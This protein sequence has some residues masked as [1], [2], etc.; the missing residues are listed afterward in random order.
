MRSSSTARRLLAAASGLGLFA[1]GMF[2]AWLGPAAAGPQAASAGRGSSALPG[3]SSVV[4]LSHVNDPARTPLFP[5]D[6][7]FTIHTAFTIAEDGFFLEVLHEGMHTGTHYSAPCHF[8]A[9]AAC[10]PDLAPSDLVLPAAVIDVRAQVRTDPDHV[11]TIADLQAWEAE[12]GDLPAGGAV[13]LFT[14]C[15]RFW[16]D[17]DTD[18]EPNYYNCGSGRSGFHQPGF[19]RNAVKWLIR[20]GVLGRTGALGS[21]TF[22]PDPSADASFTPTSLT[23]HKHRVTIENLTHLGELPALGAWVVLGSPRNVH[24]SGAPGSVFAFLP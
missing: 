24:G 17:G 15:S 3:F 8:H 2:A 18:G 14:G 16:A 21:D 9:G 13:L 5:G 12:H 6:P 10:M 22:G 23:L 20:T 11:V 4:I 19:S 1:A 7:R